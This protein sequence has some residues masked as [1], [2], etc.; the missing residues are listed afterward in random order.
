MELSKNATFLCTTDL[1]AMVTVCLKALEGSNYDVRVQVAQLLGILMAGSQAKQMQGAK[2]KKISIE[3]MF[4]IMAAG[5]LKGKDLKGDMLI[6][7][8]HLNF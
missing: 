5:F 6:I 4:G 1:D 3:D 2:G 7:L 8:Y